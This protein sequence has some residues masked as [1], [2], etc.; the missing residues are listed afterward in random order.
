MFDEMAHVLSSPFFLMGTLWQAKKFAARRFARPLARL[1]LL[2]L[3]VLVASLVLPHPWHHH[4]RSGLLGLLVVATSLHFTV[5]MWRFMR[6]GGRDGY[7][8]TYAYRQK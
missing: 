2:S 7:Y 6:Q 8:G 5:Y 3:F 1:V 4:V